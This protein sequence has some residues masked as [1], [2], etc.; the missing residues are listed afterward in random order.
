MY[1]YFFISLEGKKNNTYNHIQY[2]EY[3]S[4]LCLSLIQVCPFNE[5][6]FLLCGKS[7]VQSFLFRAGGG[8]RGCPIK[9]HLNEVYPAPAHIIQISNCG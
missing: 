3:P 1:I 7:P 9:K 8:G 2:R 4:N 6:P 5:T